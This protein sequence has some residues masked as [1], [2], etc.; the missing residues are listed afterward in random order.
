MSLMSAIP[1]SPDDAA[2]A[3]D[4][5]R[6]R[7]SQVRKADARLGKVLGAIL[8]AD[9]GIAGLMSVAPHIA[10]PA[11]LALYLGAI[12]LIIGVVVRT[13]AFSRTGLLIFSLTAFTF[14]AWI[15]VV[16]ALSV[17]TRWWSPSQPSF[18]LGVSEAIAALPLLIG[19]LLLARK[20]R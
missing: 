11:V 10:G 13:R 8:V 12:V 20:G 16:S 6:L 19:I 18:H 7:E 14:A 15:A 5:A 3:L 17:A 1:P 9:L 2:A 4:E